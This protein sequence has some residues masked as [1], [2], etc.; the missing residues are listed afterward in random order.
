MFLRSQVVMAMREQS[1]TTLVAGYS[2]RVH[3]EL[4]SKRVKLRSEPETLA[5]LFVEKVRKKPKER[6][7]C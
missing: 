4:R 6:G 2:S 5:F 1:E 3:N 7:N